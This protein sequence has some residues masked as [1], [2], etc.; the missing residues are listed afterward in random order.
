[1][2]FDLSET[3]S[4]RHATVQAIAALYLVKYRYPE[5]FGLKK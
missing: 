4:D 5:Y 3:P 2:I 1:M